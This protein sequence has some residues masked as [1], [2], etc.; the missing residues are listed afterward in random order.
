MRARARD[1][2]VI[3]MATIRADVERVRRSDSGENGTQ[4]ELYTD[5]SG[6]VPLYR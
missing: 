3:Y 1:R 4:S 5:G 6:H 2:E